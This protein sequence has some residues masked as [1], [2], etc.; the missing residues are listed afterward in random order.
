MTSTIIITIVSLFIGAIVTWFVSRRYY[1]RAASDLE[2]ETN[3]IRNLHRITLQTLE[4]SEMVKLRRD[5]SGQIIA[6]VQDGEM[7]EKIVVSASFDAV[8]EE[9]KLD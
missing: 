9:K 8:K 3:K 5:S 4:N 2:N 1:I 7:S 6:M